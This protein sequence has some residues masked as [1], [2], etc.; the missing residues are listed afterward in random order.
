MRVSARAA[1]EVVNS[2]EMRIGE[3]SV[4]GDREL[5]LICKS[6]YQADDTYDARDSSP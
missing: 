6:R 4:T 2:A 5:H 1:V 3:H